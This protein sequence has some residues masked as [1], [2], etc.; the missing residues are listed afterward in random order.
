MLVG[1]GIL[2]FCMQNLVQ[3][4][5]FYA[6]SGMM[7]RIGKVDQMCIEC[8]Y[9]IFRILTT[10]LPCAK[11]AP[12]QLLCIFITHHSGSSYCIFRICTAIY[13]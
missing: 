9:L 2:R 1:L 6:K 8:D 4:W 12:F 13:C 5:L 10:C 7:H 3:N 11:L